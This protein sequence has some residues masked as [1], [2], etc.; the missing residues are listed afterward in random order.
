MSVKTSI[1]GSKGEERG[2]RSIR[3]TF[4]EEYLVTS[5]F[6]WSGLFTP[7]QM[8]KDT[9]HLFYKTSVDYVVATK[10]GQP[11][12]AIDFDGMGAGYDLNGEYVQVEPTRDPNRKVKFDWK[13]RYARHAMMDDLMGTAL[14]Y[15]IVASE[16][17]NHLGE[18]IDLTLVDCL[19]SSIISRHQF[20]TYAKT[21]T[22]GS[23]DEAFDVEMDIRFSGPVWRKLKET[24]G[25]ISEIIGEEIN[26]LSFG[27]SEGYFW[28]D[29]EPYRV[30]LHRTPVG[31][32]SSSVMVRGG[33]YIGDE[34]VA[35][36]LAFNKLLRLLKRRESQQNG[37]SL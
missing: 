10:E 13:L 4:G 18:G 3:N 2:F 11:L 32:V 34:D 16:E 25:Q 17:F 6:P 12:V 27:L 19:I 29:Y 28:P 37:V 30:F 14:E 9:T 21:H 20:R 8:R 36:L 22:F 24:L 1:F 26:Q 23:W 31:E 5:Q 35:H 7:D 33:H 15:H